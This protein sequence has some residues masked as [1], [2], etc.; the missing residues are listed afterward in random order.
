MLCTPAD[1]NPAIGSVRPGRRGHPR[2]ASGATA[3]E[4]SY[5]EAIAIAQQ[6][7]GKLWELGAVMSLARP[8]RD[9]GKR[10]G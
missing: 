6:Q 8:W 1:N 9:Q 4:A 2:V 7:N 5:H 10:V 3:A